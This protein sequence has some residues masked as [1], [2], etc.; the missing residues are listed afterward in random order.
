VSGL[1]INGVYV[2]YGETVLLIRL[3]LWTTTEGEICLNN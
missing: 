1:M 2:L 3:K